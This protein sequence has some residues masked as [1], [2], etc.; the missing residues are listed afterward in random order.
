MTIDIT[1]PRDCTR[2]K[3]VGTIFRAGFTHEGTTY[4]DKTETCSRCHGAKQMQA[5]DWD[6][7][8]KQITTSRGLPKGQ[9][10]LLASFPSKLNHYRDR[11]AARAYYVWRLA[12][13]H[14]GKDMTMPVT[15]EMVTGGDPFMEELSAMSDIVA[16][17]F[18]GSDMAAAQRWG[19]AFGII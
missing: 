18:F 4:P 13:F 1:S 12:R 15:A 11:E 3:G 19:Q 16:K 14:G 6:L 5:P 17:R 8:L 9:S 10:K 2:C 7:I